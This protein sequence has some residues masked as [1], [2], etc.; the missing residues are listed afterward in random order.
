MSI[1]N[2]LYPLG[3]P[4]VRGRASIAQWSLTVQFLTIEQCREFI[5]M[6]M[7]EDVA[8]SD[9]SYTSD[10]TDSPILGATVHCVQISDMS[11][12]DNLTRISALLELVD[13]NAGDCDD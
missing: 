1:Q 9:I 6:L 12:A 2:K 11:W 13:Y 7:K 5:S 10:T 4:V 8:P 3:H